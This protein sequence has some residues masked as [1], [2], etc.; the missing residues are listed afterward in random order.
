MRLAKFALP[1]GGVAIAGLLVL[2]APKAAHAVAAALVQITNTASNPAI[3]QDVGQQASQMVLIYCSSEFT[4]CL[5]RAPNMEPIDN[6]GVPGL[7]GTFVVPTNETLVITGVDM[8][9]VTASSALC[10]SQTSITLNVYGSGG[11]YVLESYQPAFW[12]LSAN[13]P[14]RHF[15][16][17]PGFAIG[18]GFAP[19]ISYG[20]SSS[21][22]AS[23][24]IRGYLTAN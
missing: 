23:V 17:P 2:T 20:T 14:T 10:P 5:G 16:Y 12:V 7:N 13:A 11:V 15:T 1:L 18:P 4:T 6:T 22:Y 24:Y 19:Q 8:A 9:S 3:T 21:C